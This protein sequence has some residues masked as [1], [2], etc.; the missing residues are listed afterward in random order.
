MLLDDAIMRAEWAKRGTPTG[1]PTDT[2]TPTPTP[3]DG[4]HARARVSLSEV[5]M[6]HFNGYDQQEVVA[7]VTEEGPKEGF[8]FEV[9]YCTQLKAA[10]S[11]QVGLANVFVAWG[12]SSEVAGLIDALER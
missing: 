8:A 11:T 10:G 12:L 4:A 6:D 1:T 2:P 9:T 3:T 5:T 7:V